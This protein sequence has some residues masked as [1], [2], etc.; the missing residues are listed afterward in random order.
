M[1]NELMLENKDPIELDSANNVFVGPNNYFKIVIDDFDGTTVKAWHLEDSQGNKTE[2]LAQ[3]EGKHIDVLVSRANNTVGEFVDAMS[4]TLYDDLK[5]QVS[6]LQAGLAKAS[7]GEVESKKA[8][9]LQQTLSDKE[10]ALQQAQDNL[11]RAEDALST[12][13]DRVDQ[14]QKRVSDLQTEAQA[15]VG[16]VALWVPIVFAMIAVIAVIAV[17]ALASMYVGLSRKIT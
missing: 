17:L 3:G 12:A 10:S 15:S 4:Y 14:L 8:A 9:E 16:K 11:T 1:L 13:Q 6:E 2:N 7:S 5:A